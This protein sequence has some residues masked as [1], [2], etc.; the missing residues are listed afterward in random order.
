MCVFNVIKKKEAKMLFFIIKFAHIKSEVNKR[1]VG[2]K[3][4]L[5]CLPFVLQPTFQPALHFKRSLRIE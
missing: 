4:T 3:A 1:G 2:I 5:S